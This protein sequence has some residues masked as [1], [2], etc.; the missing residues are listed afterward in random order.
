M[1]LISESDVACL[2]RLLGE[3]AGVEGGLASRKRALMEGLCRLLEID[4]WVWGMFSRMAPGTPVTPVALVHGGFSDER[5]AAY[6]DAVEHP[7]MADFNASFLCEVYKQGTTTTRLRQELDPGNL[8]EQAEVYP[9]WQAANIDPILLSCTPF[10][11]GC[12][13]LTAM[14]RNAGKEVFSDRDARIVHLVLS[15]VPWLHLESWP[16]AKRT[17]GNLLAPRL[18]ST[19]N[20]LLEGLGR[21]QIAGHL[22]ITENTVSGYI[23]QVYRIYHVQSHAELMKYFRDGDSG[24]QAST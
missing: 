6:L 4:C 20:L 18:R 3:V 7:Q 21:K 23:K 1:D 13:S 17:R 5:Y 2:I 19:L 8:F 10:H 9:L 14:Y 16:L 24:D 15:E 22:G 12:L 11:D